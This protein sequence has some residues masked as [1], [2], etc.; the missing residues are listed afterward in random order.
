MLRKTVDNL[1]TFFSAF[2]WRDFTFLSL[3]TQRD[4]LTFVT[5][6]NNLI[7]KDW[8][9]VSTYADLLVFNDEGLDADVIDLESQEEH[10]TNITSMYLATTAN[11]MSISIVILQTYLFQIWDISER[12]LKLWDVQ[13]DSSEKTSKK[14]EK[15]EKQIDALIV[16]LERS[17]N[18]TSRFVKYSL[19]L[20]ETVAC[21]KEKRADLIYRTHFDFFFLVYLN[22]L[23]GMSEKMEDTQAQVSFQNQACQMTSFLPV[24]IELTNSR[25]KNF[26]IIVKLKKQKFSVQCDSLAY[27][28][29]LELLLLHESKP[30]WDLEN[31]EANKVL[32]FN[33]NSFI[34]CDI[35]SEYVLNAKE[36]VT[37]PRIKKHILMLF[38]LDFLGT[39]SIIQR[40]LLHL[41]YKFITKMVWKVSSS[42][43]K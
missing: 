31:F 14:C 2:F 9:F 15:K 26:A 13:D 21:R 34:D 41:S 19:C 28:L 29:A 27:K 35:S 36:C 39:H 32:Y 17:L 23:F 40:K 5:S 25:Y 18:R 1:A 3:D 33:K 20:F 38:P 16:E 8:K 30:I 22:F 6:M 24:L 43:P 12:I 42:A 11:K 10:S 4:Y 7:D 37:S